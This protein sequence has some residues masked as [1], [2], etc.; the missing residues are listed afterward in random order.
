MFT[1]T[2]DREQY[3]QNILEKLKTAKI[4]KKL[5]APKEN[6]TKNNIEDQQ[7]SGDISKTSSE[8]NLNQENCDEK[9]TETNLD[10]EKS[11]P[12]ANT[13]RQPSKSQDQNVT[14]QGTVTFFKTYYYKPLQCNFQRRYICFNI[15][16]YEK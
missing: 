4:V 16:Y 5:P 11:Y 13:D 1:A 14:L 8:S 3:K 15:K 2:I 12:D 7:K 6:S 10:C 9:S